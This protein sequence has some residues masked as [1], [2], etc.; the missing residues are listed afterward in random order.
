MITDRDFKDI[1]WK[2]SITLLFFALLS[3]AVIGAPI[4][5]MS[6]VIEMMPSDS[7]TKRISDAE[8]IFRWA[9][10]AVS[11]IGVLPLN[12]MRAAILRLFQVSLIRK[13]WQRIVAEKE[14]S[15]E[16]LVKIKA[17]VWSVYKIGNRPDA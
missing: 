2:D 16:D 4:A 3:V 17:I 9:P 7:D 10:G 14:P 15:K 6:N 12:E 1:M 5:Y 13:K 11:L 8:M